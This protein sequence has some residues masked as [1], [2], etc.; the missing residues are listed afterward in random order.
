MTLTYLKEITY[1]TRLV[2][3]NVQY[4]SLTEDRVR[5]AGGVHR[6]APIVGA[7]VEVR[8]LELLRLWSPHE[9][10]LVHAEP[11]VCISNPT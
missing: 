11:V 4:P 6:E 5:P 9:D 7:E 1:P 3:Y 2:L 8:R 10:G